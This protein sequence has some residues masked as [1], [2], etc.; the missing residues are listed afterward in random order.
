VLAREVEGGVQ[1]AGKLSFLPP[2]AFSGAPA[3]AAWDLYSLGASMYEAIT[4][5]SAFEGSSVAELRAAQ[6]NGIIPI[7]ELRPDC[8]EALAT[9]VERTFAHD[10]DDRYAS[11]AELRQALDDAYERQVDDADKHR[12]YVRLV[13]SN[14]R[15]V[16]TH[17]QLPT[18]GGFRL[19]LT[20][21]PP[22]A[23]AGL[24]NEV[25]AVSVPQKRKALRFGLSPALGADLARR[26]GTRLTDYLTKSINRDIRPVVFADYRTLVEALASGE[27][28]IAWMPPFAFVAASEL[29]AGP[30]VVAVRYGKPTYEAALFV[31]TDSPIESLQDLRGKKAAWIERESASGFQFPAAEIIRQVGKLDEVLVKQHFFG[32]H[33]QACE[34][35]LNG[36]ADVGAT[37]S[38]RDSDGKL[39]SCGWR[40]SLSPEEAEQLRALAFVGPI[41][42]DNIAHRPHLPETIRAVMAG[43][44]RDMANDE[45]GRELLRD[46]FHA[47]RFVDVDLAMYD[48]VRARLRLI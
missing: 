43:A 19:A 12:D 26:L 29:A 11:A 7:A 9:V 48:T 46:I 30:L 1:V 45:T 25:T 18:T 31:R 16:Q 21:T 6:H 27:V 39:V 41:P 3:T 36:W 23:Q 24:A 20:L 37:Y 10:P 28:D 40:D 38:S 17:G 8:P 15:F 5:K 32:S 13:F 33:Q 4:G 14:D 42:C 44:L 22:L 35:V 47:D 2:E 34:A